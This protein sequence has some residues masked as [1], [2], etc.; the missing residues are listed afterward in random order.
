MTTHDLARKL[1][2][3]PDVP[4]T[5]LD[6][7]ATVWKKEITDEDIQLY[8]SLYTGTD[9]QPKEGPNLFIA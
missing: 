9:K 7:T 4:V 1:L 3:L 2:Q 6:P 5:T 8:R